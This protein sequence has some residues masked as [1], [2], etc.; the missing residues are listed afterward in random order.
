MKLKKRYLIPLL[1]FATVLAKNVSADEQISPNNHP[2][3][4]YA[5]EQTQAS[6]IHSLLKDADPDAS[7]PNPATPAATAPSNLSSTDSTL[8]RQDVVDIASYQYWMNQADFNAL[9][10]AGVKTIAVKLT[11][12]ESYTNPYA[13]N[14]IAMA[15]AAG[16]NVATYHFVSDP[17]RI[18]YETAYYA[19]VAKS[20]GLPSS[21]VMIEDAEYPSQNF[22]WT[23]VS[24]VF[25]NTM[26]Q[27]G[28]PNVRYYF[29]QSWVSSGVVNADTLGA[30]NLWVAQYLYGKPSNQNLRNTQYGSWQYSSQMYFQGTD[31]L[32]S[33]PVDVSIDYNNIFNTV[34]PEDVYRVY[35]PNTGEHF[36]TINYTEKTK[37]VAA[38]WRDEGLGWKSPSS[39]IPVYRVY[40][41]NSKGGDHYYTQNRSEAQQL[42]DKGW[43][44]DLN[45]TPAFYSGG[46]KNLYVAYNPNAKSGSHNYTTSLFEQNSLLSKGWKY[47]AIAWKVN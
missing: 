27:N 14:Q 25:K 12:A 40:N 31:A 37:L 11:E 22:G 21:T 33:H 29:S 8:P 35:N 47:G 15:Q 46:N 44:W 42:V 20:L 4:Y 1:L 18:Q 36:Y 39:G 45:G 6:R 43:K 32:K 5:Q 19:K 23:N 41:P 30:K 24:Q 9:K 28:Y 2:M 38:G 17:T 16:L 10:A 34:L 7:T 3:G 13:K 26:T